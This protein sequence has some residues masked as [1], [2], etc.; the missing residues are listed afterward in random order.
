MTVTTSE[1]EDEGQRGEEDGKVGLSSMLDLSPT[2]KIESHQGGSISS[3]SGSLPLSP[4]AA[5]RFCQ[6][7][8][9]AGDHASVR[10]LSPSPLVAGGAQPV[11]DDGDALISTMD[12]GELRCTGLDKVS[13]YPALVTSCEDVIADGRVVKRDLQNSA[14]SLLLSDMVSRSL[15]VDLQCVEV[16]AGV[17]PQVVADCLQLRD[18]LISMVSQSS[19]SLCDLVAGGVV[20]E[21]VPPVIREAVRPQP[22]DGLGQPPRSTRVAAQSQTPPTVPSSQRGV[23]ESAPARSSA[24]VDDQGW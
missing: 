2:S 21:E 22:A 12:S 13:I 3:I 1:E 4:A 6:D 10:S 18:A 17:E 9:N 19:F 5:V 20:S 8:F 15:D 14:H 7:A 24:V 23:T 16:L 11:I